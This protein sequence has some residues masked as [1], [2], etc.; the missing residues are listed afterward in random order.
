MYCAF[1]ERVGVVFSG[2]DE[3]GGELGC[4]ELFGGVVLS[5]GVFESPEEGESEGLSP[6]LSELS[7]EEPS[8]ES[9]GLS[10]FMSLEFGGKALFAAQEKFGNKNPSARHNARKE[11][12]RFIMLPQKCNY[13]AVF[14][15]GFS[16]VK[17]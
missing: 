6:E 3:V 14:I 12:E 9:R 4:V 7:E 1:P 17:R 11:V 8:E 10:A 16:L 13:P 15:F 2:D 5:G